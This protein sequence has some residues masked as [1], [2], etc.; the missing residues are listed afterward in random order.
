VKNESIAVSRYLTVQALL[1]LPVLRPPESGG[2]LAGG[3]GFGR[4]GDDDDEE[5]EAGPGAGLAQRLSLLAA[6]GADLRPLVR[7]LSSALLKRALGEVGRG[8]GGAGTASAK[9]PTAAA[10]APAGQPLL[11]PDD[12]MTALCA[13]VRAGL[14]ERVRFFPLQGGQGVV[15]AAYCHKCGH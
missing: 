15:M 8:G 13:L 2:G 7:L 5:E 12:C 6:S 11:A 9:G 3:E 1:A 4:S 14:C 10:V